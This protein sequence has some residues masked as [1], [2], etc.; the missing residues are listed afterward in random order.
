MHRDRL[1]GGVHMGKQYTDIKDFE[2]YL[3]SEVLLLSYE[4]KIELLKMLE[5]TPCF[6]QRLSEVKSIGDI[7]PLEQAR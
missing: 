3:I 1:N 6:S 4:E 2:D 7:V 5:L